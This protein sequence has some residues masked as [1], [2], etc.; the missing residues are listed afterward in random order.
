MDSKK[1]RNEATR[2]ILKIISKP[3]VKDKE[4]LIASNQ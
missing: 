2:N 4:F 1:L 3:L